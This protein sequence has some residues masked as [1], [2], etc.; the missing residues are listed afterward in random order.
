MTTNSGPVNSVGAFVTSFRNYDVEGDQ[1]TQQHKQA[2][3]DLSNGVN[4]R[5]IALYELTELVDGQTWFTAD[6][7][8]KRYNYRKVIDMGDASVPIAHGITGNPLFFTFIYGT[9]VTNVPTYLPIPYASI[10]AFNQ[11]IELKVDAVNVTVLKGAAVAPITQCFVVLE[12][13]K[14]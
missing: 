12:Y 14:N 9:C 7:Q 1:L 11:Q 8:V 10:T 2:Y 4:Q 6:P 13:L 5:E 3:Q